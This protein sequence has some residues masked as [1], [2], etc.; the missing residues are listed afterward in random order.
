MSNKRNSCSSQVSGWKA[1]AESAQSDQNRISFDWL[2]DLED[3][4]IVF[5][6]RLKRGDREQAFDIRIDSNRLQHSELEQLQTIVARRLSKLSKAKELYFSVSWL[7]EVA[8]SHQ[9]LSKEQRA[10]RIDALLLRDHVSYK[11]RDFRTRA[12][13]FLGQT[14]TKDFIES[15][16]NSP[17]YNEVYR[18]WQTAVSKLK[19]GTPSLK[20]EDIREQEQLEIFFIGLRHHHSIPDIYAKHK[21]LVEKWSSDQDFLDAIADTTRKKHITDETK[22]SLDYFLLAGWL[23][24]AF[25]LITHEDPALILN[26]VYLTGEYEIANVSANTVRKAVKKLGLKDWT[27]FVPRGNTVAPYK[28]EFAIDREMQQEVYQFMLQS[29]GQNG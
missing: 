21:S 12:E 17:C 16:K 26:R 5:Q 13:K 23:D 9:G 1:T 11:E 8:L 7:L 10:A 27:D 18:F 24:D 28:V 20:T 15:T 6:V 2:T 25:W 3:G 14:D 29:S 4:C 22:L 19:V